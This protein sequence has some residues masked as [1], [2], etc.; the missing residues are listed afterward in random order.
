MDNLYY[1]C[2]YNC[3]DLNISKYENN[4]DI[5]IED[6]ETILVCENQEENIYKII[7]IIHETHQTININDKIEMISKSFSPCKF[8][9]SDTNK[10]ENSP[11][12]VLIKNYN[13]TALFS[14]DVNY[15]ISILLN[16]LN[17]LNYNNTNYIKIKEYITNIGFS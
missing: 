10:S 6:F 12:D 5:M 4:N 14:Y 13:N 1:V 16:T 9:Y 17:E 7:K 3:E 15:K 8:H 11:Y 2:L